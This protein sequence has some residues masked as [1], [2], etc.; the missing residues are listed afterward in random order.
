MKR[1]LLRFITGLPKKR[2]S[3]TLPPGTAAPAPHPRRCRSPAA[4]Q[5]VYFYEHAASAPS[6]FLT[7]SQVIF[8]TWRDVTT[9]STL[10]ILHRL[11]EKCRARQWDGYGTQSIEANGLTDAWNSLKG[12]L[13]KT[14]SN[15]N[16]II[17]WWGHRGV[18]CGARGPVCYSL[19]W[20]GI[21]Q[22]IVL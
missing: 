18:R 11:L 16:A 4:L 2:R 13:T 17:L 20:G 19:C 3:L 5:G 15:D 7:A 12:I 10:H 1:I 8:R 22:H 6:W 9:L 14:L 21:T